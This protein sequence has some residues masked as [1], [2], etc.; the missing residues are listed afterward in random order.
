PCS[1]STTH[2][3]LAARCSPLANRACSSHRSG[4]VPEVVFDGRRR[5][6]IEGVSPAVD[7]GRFPAKR[8]AGDVVSVEA[9][10][11]ADGHDVL[12]AVMLHRH[13]SERKA[14][15]TRMVPMVNDR[16]R[17]ELRVEQRGFYF[18]TFQAWVDH[19]LTLHRDLRKRAC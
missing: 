12:S 17:A 19:L 1:S 11:F 16:W 4:L 7:D 18:F 10:I 3:P 15:E 9:D 6:V 13:Q 5:V 8:V 14:N 2:S